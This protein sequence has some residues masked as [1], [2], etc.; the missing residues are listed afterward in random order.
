VGDGSAA[1]RKIVNP[2]STQRREDAKAQWL[3]SNRVKIALLTA[4]DAEMALRTMR[5]EWDLDVLTAAWQRAKDL[6]MDNRAAQISARMDE[7]RGS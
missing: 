3:E 5:G 7:I 6:K 2:D 1:E 4:N